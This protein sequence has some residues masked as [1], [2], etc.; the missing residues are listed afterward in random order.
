MSSHANAVVRLIQEPRAEDVMLAE[1]QEVENRNLVEDSRGVGARVPPGVGVVARVGRVPHV[2]PGD[3]IR[4]ADLVVDARDDV[5]ERVRVEARA[6]PFLVAQE[7]GRTADVRVV[8]GEDRFRDRGNSR[9]RDDVAG[10]RLADAAD[11]VDGRVADR[12]ADR[13]KV[14]PAAGR[15]DPLHDIGRH[16]ERDVPGELPE[17]LLESRVEE[18]LIAAVV[19]LRD[20]DRAAENVTAVPG[21]DAGIVGRTRWV[22]DVRAVY[23]RVLQFGPD[24]AVEAVRALLGDELGGVGRLILGV[25]VEAGRLQ[26]LDGAAGLTK[27]SAGHHAGRGPVDRDAPV[28]GARAV[29]RHIPAAPQVGLAGDIHHERVGN[30]LSVLLEDRAPVQVLPGH[31]DGHGSALGL[32]LC[33]AGRDLDRLG[34][35]A[36]LHHRVGPDRRAGGH[37]KALEAEILE[38]GQADQDR[39]GARKKSRDQVVAGIRG[40]GGKTEAGGFIGRL[41][42]GPGHPGLGRIGY[43]THDGTELSLG[44]GHGNDDQQCCNDARQTP[45]HPETSYLALW[46]GSPSFL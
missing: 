11:P 17:S 39:V 7:E 31:G 5:P 42:R 6:G 28:G 16:G 29:C 15:P 3:H 19:D 12:P 26:V 20:V 8:L 38:P 43:D 21:G 40:N 36:D 2:G 30:V 41:Y 32:Q 10:K 34:G 27:T 9:R 18:R 35:G 1:V 45:K 4:P 13:G 25:G 44:L 24:G 22:G 23:G 33:P 14:V 37:G 46:H